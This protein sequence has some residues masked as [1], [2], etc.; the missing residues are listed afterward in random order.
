MAAPPE[1]LMEIEIIA[2][3]PDGLRR[4]VVHLASGATARDALQA[5]GLADRPQARHLGCHGRLIS[6]DTVLQKGD[7][8]ELL[9]PLLADPKEAR[10]A[11]VRERRR[12]QRG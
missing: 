11:K 5:S 6:P 9:R 2:D 4:Q 10:R 12:R 1:G 3:L 8:V 7:R